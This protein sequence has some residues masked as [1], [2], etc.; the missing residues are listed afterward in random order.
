MTAGGPFIGA[1]QTAQKWAT[2]NG[3]SLTPT[4]TVWSLTS[5]Y[6]V[7]Q[8]D[9]SAACS[10]GKKISLMEVVNLGHLWPPDPA[11]GI[12]DLNG[13]WVQNWLVNRAAE[14]STS[15]TTSLA[16]ATFKV[17]DRVYTTSSNINVRSC[18]STSC[19]ILGT[20]S[21]NAQ[22]TIIG[23]PVTADGFVW[24]NINYDSGV[25]G[26]SVENYLKK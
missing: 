10:S 24:W 23:G 2:T 18:A 5:K 26:W 17:N 3:C 6:Q 20:K 12:T 13:A 11:L 9:Y 25:D 16:P 19:A 15:A 22:G 14:V 4:N 8:H 1:V 21:L 7:N